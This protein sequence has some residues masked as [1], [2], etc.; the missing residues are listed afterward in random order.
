MYRSNVKADLTFD[1]WI[2]EREESD[3]LNVIL[4]FL[5]ETNCG[6]I[7]YNSPYD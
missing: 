1:P 7:W 6:L 5:G 4:L 2:Y 3:K